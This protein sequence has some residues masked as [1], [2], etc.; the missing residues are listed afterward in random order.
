MPHT[1]VG[2]P[3]IVTSVEEADEIKVAIIE[4]PVVIDVEGPIPITVVTPRVGLQGPP[5]PAGTDGASISTA[6][7]TV[8]TFALTGEIKIDAGNDFIPPFY[9]L[10]SATQT[11]SI[12]RVRHKINSGTNVQCKLQ[13]NGV[14]IPGF[15]GISVST[16]AATTDPAN[17][18]LTDGDSIALVIT[19]ATGIPRDLTF[20]VV[21]EHLA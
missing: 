3:S 21:L 17:V 19:G 15:T 13:R 8:H 2:G 10:I 7:Q 12:A 1:V 18:P 4:Q 5:G 16:A 11:T 20:T 14:D 6:F 9:V